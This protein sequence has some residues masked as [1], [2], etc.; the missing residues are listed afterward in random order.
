MNKNASADEIKKAVREIVQQHFLPEFLN[1]IDETI[2]FKPLTKEEIR[3]IVGL[4]LKK[5][6]ALLEK[7]GIVFKVTEKAVDAVTESGY[8]VVYGARPLKR[9]IQREIQNPLTL[10]L[11]ES[12]PKD[13]DQTGKK[14]VLTVDFDGEKFTFIQE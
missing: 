9:V 5:L 8:D 12:P 13:I 1:R 3:Q 4:Q 14:P 10:R 6:G 11:L 7:Q 2:I